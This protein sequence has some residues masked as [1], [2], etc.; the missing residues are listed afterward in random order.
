MTLTSLHTGRDSG[1]LNV[2]YSGYSVLKG[3]LDLERK[4]IYGLVFT[5]HLSVREARDDPP[6]CIPLARH[7]RPREACDVPCV[8][9]L[10][11]NFKS[12]VLPSIN[13]SLDRYQS[14]CQHN[15]N[16]LF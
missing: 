15:C 13:F 14:Y 6:A 9:T 11:S 12:G 3:V 10:D 7:V 5:R 8:Y 1:A 2:A 4:N 16:S